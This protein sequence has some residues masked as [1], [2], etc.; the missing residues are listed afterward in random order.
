MAA[1]LEVRD[2]QE[3]ERWSLLLTAAADPTQTQALDS[4]RRLI[5]VNGISEAPVRCVLSAH[6]ELCSVLINNLLSVA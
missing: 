2:E 5:L 1:L 3:D 6:P 4:I